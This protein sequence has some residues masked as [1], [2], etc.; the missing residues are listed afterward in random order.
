MGRTV[1]KVIEVI[2]PMALQAL[3]TAA[4]ALL[5]EEALDER[6]ITRLKAQSTDDLGSTIYNDTSQFVQSRF[7]DAYGYYYQGLRSKPPTGGLP[8]AAGVDIIVFDPEKNITD[9]NAYLQTVF[10]DSISPSD[11]INLSQN[12]ATLF[13][14][15]FK[16][17]SFNWTSFNKRYNFQD[18]LIVD[19][20][21]VTAAA[22]DV[23]NNLAGV[24][25]YCF[26]AYQL[27]N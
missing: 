18:N 19:T 26:V 6:V 2:A 8:V 10:K 22:N 14:D 23:D 4:E 20:Y 15:R 11:A 3:A 24:A 9:I 1:K 7:A 16:E 21:L 27:S 5:A 13:Q 25:T 12:L 17:E